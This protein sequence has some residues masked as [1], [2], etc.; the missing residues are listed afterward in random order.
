MR[1]DPMNNS[2]HPPSTTGIRAIETTRFPFEHLTALAELESWRKEINRP[3]YHVHKWW[4]Q[5]LGSVFRAILLGTF[6]PPDTDIL[7]CFYQP[8]DL[9][10]VIVFDPFMGSGTTIGEALKLGAR[11]IG[12]DINPVAYRSVRTV[13]R[14]YDRRAVMETFQA[15]ERD[16]APTIRH[17]YQARL[18]SGAR[19]EVLYYFWVAVVP[20][21]RCLAPVD[22][23]SSSIFAQHAYP[24][25]HPEAR[26]I[27]PTC[28]AINTV[29][30]DATE[31][32][33]TACTQHFQ[34]H[35]G[36]V[37]G[38]KA[39][40]PGCGHTFPIIKAVQA[41]GRPPDHRLYAKLVLDGAGGKHYLPADA[42]D[43]ALYDAATAALAQRAARGGAYPIV[44]IEPGYN[45]NQARNYGYTHWHQLFN[46][47]QLLC[48]SLLAERIRVIPEPDLRE[49]FTVLFSGTLEF[50][51]LFA[52]YKGE[53]TGAVRHMF[54][55]HILKPERTPLE[56]N[57]WGTPKSSGAFSTLFRS[58]LLRSLD[59]AEHPFELRI[60]Q[61]QGKATGTKVY[62][63]AR[64]LG[65]AVVDSFA[66]FSAGGSLY[67]SCGDSASTDLPAGSVDAIVTD[68]PFFDNVH[69]SQLADFFHVWQRH[70]LDREGVALAPSTRSSA[71]VQHEDAAVFTGRLT[72]I[73]RECARVLQADGLLVFTYHHS[74][75]DGWRAVLA[76]LVG[77]GFQI[78]AV[79]PIKA[80]LSVAQ[81][82]SQ[83]KE[84]IDLDVIIVCRRRLNT[85]VSEHDRPVPLDEAAQEAMAQLQRFA[86]V[87]KRLS[88]NDV[89]VI[90]LGQ[91]V[92]RLSAWSVLAEALAGLAAA[93]A[94]IET[95]I[96][97]LYHAQ[98]SLT[99]ATNGGPVQLTLGLEAVT[100]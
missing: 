52:S 94:N 64:P 89:R 4:A 76:A 44:P 84:P 35:Q 67:L 87:G 1:P 51:N 42:A 17:F 70:I 74:R 97:R 57:V 27:C 82:K 59:Y 9:G 85:A 14:R 32:T 37:R 43:R 23:F 95:T 45:T 26:A 48:L 22:L 73:W 99:T 8:V 20:C 60:G 36:P 12:R 72:G 80:E 15:I 83:A 79:H 49:L 86:D 96:D 91:L 38:A 100:R 13:L 56:A 61:R 50:N 65:Q 11:A 46:A 40:C 77:A 29:R 69:Y 58:R 71:E 10:P 93:E 21:P 28:G 88:R 7:A 25:R 5:R 63:L 92:K 41:Q 19:G 55:H 34:P 16:V 31:A 24:Q 66:S 90:V 54:S 18:P 78:V 6:L 33:C 30:Y 98:S 62:G 2:T 68:P 3:I 39:T 75:A 47:R 53:G 81:P